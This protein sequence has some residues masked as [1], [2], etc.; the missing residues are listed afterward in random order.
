M[1]LFKKG[2]IICL[3]A[4]LISITLVPAVPVSAISGVTLT[5]GFGGDYDSSQGHVEYK[6]NDGEWQSVSAAGDIDL[7]GAESLILKVVP[8]KYYE[9]NFDT[10]P[11]LEDGGGSLAFQ[12]GDQEENRA[13]LT[14]DGYGVNLTSVTEV[15][16]TGV[17]FR[18]GGTAK[19]N[20]PVSINI[21][22][23]GQGLE[24]WNGDYPS[25]INFFINTPQGEH[26][27]QH[28]K[29]GGAENLEWKGN[30]EIDGVFVKNA[31]GVRTKNPVEITYDYDGKEFVT[32]P[33]HISNAS[34]KITSFKVNG[35][36]FKKQC[37]QSDEDFLKALDAA[38]GVVFEI[39]DVPYED[40]YDIEIVAEFN[41][42]MGGFGWNYLSDKDQTGGDRE[43]CIAHGTLTFIKGEYNGE[44]F[45]SVE[46]WNNYRYDEV[47][48]IFEWKDGDKNYTDNRDAWG[49]AAFP[50]DAKITMKLIPDEGYQ[51]VSLYGDKNV[52]PDPL[53]P[54]VY[55]I[56]MTGG[57]NSHL[58][59]TFEEVGDTVN[60]SAKAV[61]DGQVSNLHNEY[62]EGTM[63]LNVQDTETNAESRAAF[64]EKASQE[65][66]EIQEY[67]DINLANTIYKATEKA[68]DAWDR[69]VFELEKPATIKLELE[70]SYEGKDIVIIHEHNGEYETIPVTFDGRN[71]ISFETSSFSN[72][73]IATVE[74]TEEK[75]DPKDDQKPEDNPQDDSDEKEEYSLEDPE[76]DFIV[77]FVDN[78][79]VPFALMVVDLANLTD[80]QLKEMNLSKEE[81]KTTMDAFKATL[82]GKGDFLGAYEIMVVNEDNGSSP[83]G[84]FL[85]KI[86]I[87]GDMKNYSDFK[88]FD[89]NAFGEEGFSPKEIKITI[90]DGYIVAEV[91]ELGTYAITGVQ[92]EK[93]DKKKSAPTTGDEREIMGWIVIAVL[94]G[95]AVTR[96]KTD[97]SN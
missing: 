80:A 59:A 88:L 21:D 37:P 3:A 13:K 83:K 61:K 17:Q 75:D 47:S 54:G 73:A 18:G 2:L 35:T 20:A 53:E 43:D 11:Q 1:K 78:K 81:Y 62:G 27:E 34:T 51:L 5:I 36:E 44:V 24:Y 39:T 66:A 22:S 50:R 94:A 82:K 64:E 10:G 60:A 76:G 46:E 90:E 4:L 29:W 72:Y 8:E 56:T 31:D 28:I 67:I 49:S 96:F 58:M 68:D 30:Y 25:R 69:P 7:V 48:Q 38:R 45:N 63:K 70:N 87:T 55:T 40:H 52:E 14:G 95:V 65:D 91:D 42:L 6:V 26:E 16:L 57:M 23:T 86:K 85:L 19:E 89:M 9:V 12:A 74:P 92:E 77:D 41:D 15:S 32:I 93:A 84:P 79:D 33:V 71:T 97:N